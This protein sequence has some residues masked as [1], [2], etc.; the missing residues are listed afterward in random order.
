M[1]PEASKAATLNTPKVRFIISPVAV[2]PNMERAAGSRD[3]DLT[4]IGSFRSFRP[5]RP[6]RHVD[7]WHFEPVRCAGVPP[8]SVHA[9]D[10]VKVWRIDIAPDR[11]QHELVCNVNS[12]DLSQHYGPI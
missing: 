9:A 4:T 12:D 5:N 2:N 8:S 7:P 1:P 11:I 6:V 3:A 10:Q